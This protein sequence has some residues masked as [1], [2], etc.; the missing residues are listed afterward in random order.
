MFSKKFEV[1]DEVAQGSY[2]LVMALNQLWTR[3]KT[4]LKEMRKRESIRLNDFHFG[5]N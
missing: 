1:K 5:N 3:N 4:E 2:D